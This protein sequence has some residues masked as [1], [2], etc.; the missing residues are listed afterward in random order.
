M[1]E[2][3]TV[4]FAAPKRTGKQ[5]SAP[6]PGIA[7]DSSIAGKRF[8]RWVATGEYI[9]AANGERKLL[10]RCDC[11]TERYV[12]ERSLRRGDSQSCGC[13]RN[14]RVRQAVT[15][16]LTGH[17]FGGLTVLCQSEAHSG[18]WKCRCECGKECEYTAAELTSGKKT[19]CGCKNERRC[20][21]A[22]ITGG[23]FGRLTAL[24]PTEKRDA[25]G[26]V[27]W[28]CRCDCGNEVDISYN[29]LMYSHRTSCGCRKR[30][31][32]AELSDYLTRVDGTSIDAIKSR[33]L[34]RNNTTGYRGVYYIR[35]RYVAKIVFKKKQYL[36]GSFDSAE[37]AAAAR[38]GA[39][40]RFESE[41]LGYYEKWSAKAESDHEWARENP[42]RIDI[43]RSENGELDFDFSP[44]L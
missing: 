29:A 10:C 22:D 14:E 12:L 32:N 4:G 37:A 17:A 27:I 19:S 38:A 11:G 24:Y 23:R 7:A 3:R 13:L 9:R 33:T 44:K 1:E 6:A 40:E 20:A 21:F 43:Q 25:K 31:H 16:D 34:P 18:Y 26:F 15:R 30:E 41:I 5:K 35:G 2:N 42:A 28:H 39:Q 36:L 8:G